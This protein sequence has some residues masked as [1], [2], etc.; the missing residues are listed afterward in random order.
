[1]PWRC[2]AREDLDN[3]HA[4]AAA[5]TSWFAWIDGGSGRLAFRCCG[6]QLTRACDVVGASA[7]GEQAV[8]ADAVQA[9]SDLS[10]ECALRAGCPSTTLN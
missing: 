3:D 5:W 2:T 4:T 6:E 1:M 7:F 10:P 9:I 8:V